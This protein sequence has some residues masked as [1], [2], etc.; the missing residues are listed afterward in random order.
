MLKQSGARAPRQKLQ[1][2]Y[3]QAGHS[4]ADRARQFQEV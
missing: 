3:Q 4:A 2:A 1:H